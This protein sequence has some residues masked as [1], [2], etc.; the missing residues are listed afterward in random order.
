MLP[1]HTFGVALLGM[2]LVEL[3]LGNQGLDAGAAKGEQ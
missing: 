1:T 3:S 2:G